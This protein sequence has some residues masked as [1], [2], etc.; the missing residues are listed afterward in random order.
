MCYR[1]NS[2]DMTKLEAYLAERP[3]YAD[4]RKDA[5][6]ECALEDMVGAII[7]EF[8]K[9]PYHISGEEEIPILDI[10]ECYAQKMRYFRKLASPG[11]KLMFNIAVK[12]A[13][14]LITLFS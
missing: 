8:E 2:K 10:L 11:K 13:E 6:A 12:E 5:Y 14:G 9:P 4:L 1:E 7:A 3:S